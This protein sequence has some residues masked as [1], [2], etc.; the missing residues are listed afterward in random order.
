[1]WS[2]KYASAITTCTVFTAFI[3]VILQ[4][5]WASHNLSKLTTILH[6]LIYL[7][8]S[9]SSVITIAPHIA[10]GYGSCSDLFVPAVKFLNFSNELY[11]SLPINNVDANDE[12][13]SVEDITSEEELLK[14]FGYY[15]SNGAASE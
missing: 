13:Y 12:S 6:G 4:A 8:N 3:A 1:M 7:E 9:N 10:I 2:T 15:F 14:S 5:Y 11:Q